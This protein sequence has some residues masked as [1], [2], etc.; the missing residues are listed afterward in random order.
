VEGDSLLRVL[1]CANVRG[2]TPFGLAAHRALRTR[3]HGYLPPVVAKTWEEVVRK[4]HHAGANPLLC[5]EDFHALN[6]ILS[7]GGGS[8]FHEQTFCDTVD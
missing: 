1:N 7:G 8:A 3:N 5:G 4:L 6:E 2:N